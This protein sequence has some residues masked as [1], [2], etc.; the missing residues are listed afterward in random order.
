MRS[1]RIIL[2]L[3]EAPLPFGHAVGRWYY[4]LLRGLVE[5]G[6]RVCCFAICNDVHQVA[7][8]RRLFPAPSFDLRIYSHP[9]RSGLWKKWQTLLRPFSYMIDPRLQR[10]IHAECRQG[11][12]VL[13]LEGIWSGWLGRGCD[14][15]KVVLNF[16]SLYDIDQELL[17]AQGWREKT[18]RMLRRKAEHRLLRSSGT[19]LT[20]TPRL[21]QAVRSIAPYT[22]VH[23]VPLGMD[24][25]LYPYI[26]TKRRATE[27]VVSVIGTM[28][29]YP[30]YSAAVRLLTRLAPAIRARLPETQIHIVGWGARQALRPYLSQPATL[31]AESV[32]DTR[33]YFESAGVF[34]YAPERGSGMK[35]KVMEA[36]AYGIPVVTTSEGIEG[37][38]AQDGIH[39][40]CSDEDRELVERTVAL[41]TDHS[42]QELQRRAAREL[43]HQ[44]C[45]PVVVLEALQACYEDMA[46]RKRRQVA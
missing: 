8:A 23:V 12:D 34:L 5:R 2:V 29:W 6:H 1:L 3:S 21:A 42:R 45:R 7:E 14:P 37:I 30:S 28:H 46:A 18:L 33:P 44:H 43:L 40:G 36:F 11:F 31:I 13:H 17:P 39:V 10:D 4:V 20:L 32:P 15:A 16:H 25:S 26:P 19:L 41:L 27:P 22:P 24:L 38:P 35:V 9:V